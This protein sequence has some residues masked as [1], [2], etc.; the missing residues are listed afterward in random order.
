MRK[1][2]ASGGVVGT[3]RRA[4]VEKK[5][6]FD[7]T[8][9]FQVNYYFASTQ[10]DNPLSHGYAVPAPLDFGRPTRVSRYR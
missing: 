1:F 4:R 10:Q 5:V 9:A 7:V 3:L 8:I 6:L 2:R